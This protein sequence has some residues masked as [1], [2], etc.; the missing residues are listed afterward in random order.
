MKTLAAM[1]TDP[2]RNNGLHLYLTM[3]CHDS[4]VS[5]DGPAEL[6]DDFTIINVINKQFLCK[7]Q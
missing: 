7:T 1:A 4:Q 3:D 6:V 5:K 2:K